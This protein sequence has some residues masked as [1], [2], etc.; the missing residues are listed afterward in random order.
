M[1]KK[2][3]FIASQRKR[4]YSSSCNLE[5]LQ[6]VIDNAKRWPENKNLAISHDVSA[7]PQRTHISTF[8]TNG[9]VT[10]ATV[11]GHRVLDFLLDSNYAFSR[12]HQ[13]PSKVASHILNPT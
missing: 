6:S 2:T 7:W 12:H 13:L 5:L 4:Y 8:Y 9:A 11:D 1:Y 10:L 3:S